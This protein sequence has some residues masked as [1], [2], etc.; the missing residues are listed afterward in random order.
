MV[1]LKVGGIG[2][3]RGLRGRGGGTGQV[4]GTRVKRIM[5]DRPI[6]TG[7][8][9]KPVFS[10]GVLCPTMLDARPGIRYAK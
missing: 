10:L 5:K 1:N 2:I 6:G 9:E 3:F 7:L 8:T 4:A